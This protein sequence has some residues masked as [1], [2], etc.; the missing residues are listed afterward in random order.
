MLSRDAKASLVGN[1][2][3]TWYSD[4]NDRHS[5]NQDIHEFLALGSRTLVWVIG[6]ISD[7]SEKQN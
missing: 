4:N 2:L 1:K 3:L 5:D 7:K 6:E